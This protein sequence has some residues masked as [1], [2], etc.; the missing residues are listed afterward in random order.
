MQ[1]MSSSSKWWMLDVC[2]NIAAQA[3]HEAEIAIF[4]DSH[5]V[6]VG[7]PDSKIWWSQGISCM[8]KM[9]HQCHVHW[10]TLGRLVSNNITQ[11][12]QHM[13]TVGVSYILKRGR[14][15]SLRGCGPVNERLP[16]FFACVSCVWSLWPIFPVAVLHATIQLFLSLVASRGWATNTKAQIDSCNITWF[17]TFSRF[18]DEILKLA[19]SWVL[20]WFLSE[21]WIWQRVLWRDTQDRITE[22]CGLGGVARA[23]RLNFR[24]VGWMRC[25]HWAV[26]QFFCLWCGLSHRQTRVPSFHTRGTGGVESSNHFSLRQVI[27]ACRPPWVRF[28]L[29]GQ[30]PIPAESLQLCWLFDIAGVFATSTSWKSP[31]SSSI[32]RFCV[33]ASPFVSA[34]LHI[35]FGAAVSLEAGTPALG[36]L[37]VSHTRGRPARLEL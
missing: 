19:S 3:Q 5:M 23:W 12:Q 35:I 15:R 24:D 32:L 7:D 6:T 2:T 11:S 31:A 37:S 25:A 20:L 16:H 21:L 1:H 13:V 26:P 10:C 36:P 30:K 22:P 33:S 29:R 27:P 28:P 14:A 4:Y 18:S 8:D 17:R 9:A 34:R